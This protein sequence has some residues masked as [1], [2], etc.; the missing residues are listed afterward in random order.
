[1]GTQFYYLD[2]GDKNHYH[3]VCGIS[4]RELIKWAYSQSIALTQ[5]TYDGQTFEEIVLHKFVPERGG[6]RQGLGGYKDSM[7]E[8]TTPEGALFSP[9]DVWELVQS[10]LRGDQLLPLSQWLAALIEDDDCFEFT[11]FGDQLYNSKSP[12]DNI[13]L[14]RNVLGG[15]VDTNYRFW[16]TR[17][18]YMCLNYMT[19][20]QKL[21]YEYGLL[22]VTEVNSYSHVIVLRSPSWA[23]TRTAVKLIFKNI[24]PEA[25]IESLARKYLSDNGFGA[26]VGDVVWL[27]N[28]VVKHR[29]D[30]VLRL[31]AFEEY[32]YLELLFRF[33]GDVDDSG[34]RTTSYEVYREV[35]RYVY[36]F[37]GSNDHSVSESD[38]S[39]HFLTGTICQFLC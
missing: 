7:L 27:A 38:A 20:V 19:Q 30:R 28:G 33:P 39:F 2:V 24:K 15:V 17:E 23:A 13:R 26:I 5:R 35:R 22:A 12:D 18:E 34:S 32:L 4:A 21:L 1:V 29:L 6:F 37:R 14:Y 8:S 16:M 31:Y 9:L 25:T 3:G 11:T 10:L 36:N